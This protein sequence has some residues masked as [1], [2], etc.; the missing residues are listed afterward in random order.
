MEEV[1]E[2]EN[3]AGEGGCGKGDRLERGGG[4]LLTQPGSQEFQFPG[5]HTLQLVLRL[6]EAPS[7]ASPGQCLG[8]SP[9]K[10]PWRVQGRNRLE[11]SPPGYFLT[12]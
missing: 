10:H 12:L 5:P 6:P 1:R 2:E 11:V 4:A 3:G 8:L 7:H 9:H